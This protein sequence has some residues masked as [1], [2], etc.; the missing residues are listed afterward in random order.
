VRR[1]SKRDSAIAKV[2]P[3]ISASSPAVALSSV[4]MFV[5]WPSLR[6]PSRQPNSLT[7]QISARPTRKMTGSGTW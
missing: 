2:N 6:F 3:M 4:L 1:A 7:H 5:L